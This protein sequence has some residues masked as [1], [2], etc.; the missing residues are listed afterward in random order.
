ML[1]TS[2]KAIL[3]E[4]MTPSHRSLWLKDDKY[5]L[6]LRSEKIPRPA[7]L[8]GKHNKNKGYIEYDSWSIIKSLDPSYTKD[9]LGHD[10]DS[11]SDLNSSVLYTSGSKLLPLSCDGTVSEELDGNRMAKGIEFLLGENVLDETPWTV[12]GYRWHRN[13]EIVTCR[14]GRFSKS[15]V[16]ERGSPSTRCSGLVH[17][18]PQP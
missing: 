5:G 4:Q 3:D 12:F 7:F 18:A 2:W 13:R 1:T 16:A 17:R 9:V 14:Q 6:S 8:G 11:S 10:D 15:F